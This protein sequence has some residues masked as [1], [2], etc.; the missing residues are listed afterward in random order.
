[1]GGFVID[2]QMNRKHAAVSKFCQS[3]QNLFRFGYGLSRV[4]H[5]FTA[6]LFGIRLPKQK[7]KE[8]RKQIKIIKI[9]AN[10]KI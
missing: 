2:H 10:I 7:Q 5:L 6:K 4:F 9:K 8:F 1:M 3:F